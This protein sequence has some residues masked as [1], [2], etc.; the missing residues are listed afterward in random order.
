MHE[1]T[2][3]NIQHEQNS[4]IKTTVEWF[5]TPALEY[6]TLNQII[7]ILSMIQTYQMISILIYSSKHSP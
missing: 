6:L 4:F 1:L 7:K 5:R 2:Q 3:G